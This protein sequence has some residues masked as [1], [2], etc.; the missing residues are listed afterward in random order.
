MFQNLSR[1]LFDIIVVEACTSRISNFEDSEFGDAD[2]E[3]FTGN[4]TFTM[5]DFNNNFHTNHDY[6]SYTYGLWAPLFKEDGR[7]ALW[8]DG[9]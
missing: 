2:V 7:L 5:N 1:P 9:F 6:N 3:Q 8:K 4:L